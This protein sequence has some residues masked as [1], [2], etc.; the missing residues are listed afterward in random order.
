[1]K[2]DLYDGA[3]GNFAL[4]L[5]RSIR[6]ETYGED[7]G[8]TSWVTKAE[9]DEITRRLALNPASNVLEIGC[10]SGQFAVNLSTRTGCRT[11]GLDV[12]S[13]AIQM[14]SELIQASPVANLLSF[15]QCDVS[16]SLPFP[17]GTFD[18][19]FS[20]DAICHL[21]GRAGV[22]ADIFRILKPGGRF[23]FSDALVI[24]GMVS[25]EEL[26]TRSSIGYYVYSPPGEN[27]R[28][29]VQAGFRLLEAIDTTTNVA[30]VAGRWRDARLRR[31]AA[32]ISIE[33][34]AKFEGLQRF[35]S[36][37]HDLCA[38]RRLLRFLYCAGKEP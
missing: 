38:E 30:E 27:E 37:V 12:N 1:M 19:C 35:L 5:Y 21:P 32:L 16:K 28:L 22:L 15:K 23:L 4:D 2:I 34:D 3:Y 18:A 17:V 26:S 33:G 20:N 10:G 31:K 25:Q 13:N 7:L 8:Q 24:G 6:V 29:I 11:T 36:C 9:G 14:A